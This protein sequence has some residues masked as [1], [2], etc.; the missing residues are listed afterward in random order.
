LGL[1]AG[2]TLPIN[3]AIWAEL[4]GTRYLGEIKSLSTSIV[5]VS[6]ALSPFIIGL[7]LEGGYTLTSVLVVGA[8]TCL[9]A[10]LLVLPVAF[11]GISSPFSRK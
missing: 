6:T 4:Y 1:G 5:V 10:L 2:I 7:A 3:N 11:Q 9:V 8:A